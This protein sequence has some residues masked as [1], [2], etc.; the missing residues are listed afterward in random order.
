MTGIREPLWGLAADNIRDQLAAHRPCPDCDTP[1][2]PTTPC[3][4]CGQLPGTPDPCQ[5]ADLKGH[6]LR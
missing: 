6:P 1:T 2:N 5:E 4:G 3:P